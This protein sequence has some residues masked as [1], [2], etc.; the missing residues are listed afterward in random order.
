MTHKIK[1]ISPRI[2]WFWNPK[3]RKQNFFNLPPGKLRDMMGQVLTEEQYWDAFDFYNKD[4]TKT[5]YGTPPEE[6]IEEV[7]TLTMKRYGKNLII[8][9]NDYS[10]K[11]EPRTLAQLI[12]QG[13]E[14]C[15]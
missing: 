12:W 1:Y 13:E 4:K 15:F 14:K 8:L 5:L 6:E 11:I 9:L 3:T 2:L 7:K 10:I